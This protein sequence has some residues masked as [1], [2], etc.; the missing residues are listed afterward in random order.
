MNTL[1]HINELLFLL[2]TPKQDQ[3]I[4]PC[5]RSG[6]S[7]SGRGHVLVRFPHSVTRLQTLFLFLLF[8]CFFMESPDSLHPLGTTKASNSSGK[9]LATLC[10][11]K[12]FVWLPNP[13]C[14]TKSLF[15]WPPLPR[16]SCKTT[17]CPTPSCHNFFSSTPT[18][19][20]FSTWHHLWT[21]NT[22]HWTAP[23]A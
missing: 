3:V 17:F 11:E 2:T 6:L 20:P 1:L 7:L 10:W 16:S 22:E 14:Y 18:P 23:K 19:A 13:P 15:A 8:M 5:S 9:K 21:L 12:P 4:S